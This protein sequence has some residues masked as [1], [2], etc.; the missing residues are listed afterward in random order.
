MCSALRL[1]E[2]DMVHDE[3][4]F[5]FLSN[6]RK[7]VVWCGVVLG[8]WW[9]VWRDE[10][11]CG[12]LHAP[13][14]SQASWSRSEEYTK[15]SR[16]LC[17]RTRTSCLAAG[18]PLP[19]LTIQSSAVSLTKFRMLTRW[20]RTGSSR[21]SLKKKYHGFPK[22]ASRCWA[23]LYAFLRGPLAI[24]PQLSMV[25]YVRSF[26][27]MH[28]RSSASFFHFS[29]QPPKCSFCALWTRCFAVEWSWASWLRCLVRPLVL[30]RLCKPLKRIVTCAVL[31]FENFV[32][33]AD[34][35]GRLSPHVENDFPFCGMCL[36]HVS[37][38]VV[39]SMTTSSVMSMFPGLLYNFAVRSFHFRIFS[40]TL[41]RFFCKLFLWSAWRMELTRF[42]IRSSLFFWS[43][44]SNWSPRCP[45]TFL[46]CLCVRS[47]VGGWLW[48]GGCGVGGGQSLWE[49]R[50][51]QE[52]QGPH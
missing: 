4:F 45:T 9:C 38:F 40:L 39:S 29:A 31:R 24:S 18:H 23:W 8:W 19:R 26:S 20:Y 30:E 22:C 16:S 5:S 15:I 35:S 44:S 28:L 12:V 25:S 48:L 43:G 42:L 14:K 3:Y 47:W 2:W 41:E 34:N 11:D 51:R 32:F 49:G 6:T 46:K 7:S 13:L 36:L 37:H 17:L 1:V 21:C 10:N 27:C 52:C 33:Y 50:T